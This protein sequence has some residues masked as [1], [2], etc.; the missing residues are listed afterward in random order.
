MEPHRG[1]RPPKRVV[2]STA[3]ASSAAPASASP[4]SHPGFVSHDVVEHDHMTAP[5]APSASVLLPGALREHASHTAP[6][7]PGGIVQPAGF[8]QPARRAGQG[9]HQFGNSR[10]AR[11]R[12]E[13][14]EAAAKKKAEAG[15]EPAP[16]PAP[17]AERSAAGG[18]ADEAA[19]YDLG[20]IDRE[21]AER[22]SKMS[23]E[24]IERAQSDL[25]GMLS[26]ELLQRWKGAAPV[27]ARAAAGGEGAEPAPA[28][29][30]E[31]DPAEDAAAELER[32]KLE[33]TREIVVDVA[34][35]SDDVSAVRYGFEGLPMA[36]SALVSAGAALH[37][38]GEQPDK[39]GYTLAE[40]VHLARSTV[41]GQRVICVE[42]LG[43]V[44]RHARANRSAAT[45]DLMLSA[46]LRLPLLLR[47][48]LDDRS[49]SVV[50]AAIG[51][52]HALLNAPAG[53]GAAL[54]VLAAQYQ[55]W[56]AFPLAPVVALAEGG[57]RLASAVGEDVE[58]DDED[59][60]REDSVGANE[61]L[62]G[63]DLVAGFE[64]MKVVARMRY[65]LEMVDLPRASLVVVLGLL[66]RMTQHSR[67]IATRVAE[68]AGLLPCL[69]SIHDS[70]VSG[71]QSQEG[72]AES[73]STLLMAT[74]GLFE[75]VA[76]ASSATACALSPLVVSLSRLVVPQAAVSTAL[77]IAA[78]R[79]W[80][81]L[82]CHDQRLQGDRLFLRPGHALLEVYPALKDHIQ[83]SAKLD[84]CAAL[85]DCFEVMCSPMQLQ[86]DGV[87]SEALASLTSGSVWWLSELLKADRSDPADPDALT[88]LQLLGSLLHFLS[89][90]TR[91]NRAAV[92]AVSHIEGHI[93]PC[94]D[95]PLF[96]AA[97]TK[98]KAGEL[99]MS[100]P[101]A[102][103]EEDS[104]DRALPC[105]SAA[106]MPVAVPLPWISAALN[107]VLG[108][109][110]WVYHC[111][112]S[113]QAALAKT[114]EI[115]SILELVRVASSL[116][117]AFDAGHG[118]ELSP[119]Q[120][121]MVCRITRVHSLLRFYSLRLG[122]LLGTFS[123]A[124]QLSIAHA[125]SADL[126]TSLGPGDEVI[127]LSALAELFLDPGLLGDL[128]AAHSAEA[129]PVEVADIRKDLLIPLAERTIGLAVNLQSADTKVQ[130]SGGMIFGLDAQ[131]RL[132]VVRSLVCLAFEEP[133]GVND[134][135]RAH[136]LCGATKLMLLLSE[137]TSPL[138]RSLEPEA[139][140]TCSL[141]VME[142]AAVLELDDAV[143]A[144][145]ALM[146]GHVSKLALPA[147]A[148]KQDKLIERLDVALQTFSGVTFGSPVLARA[149]LLL[150]RNNQPV[151]YR[152]ALW[153]HC[154][155]T[156]VHNCLAVAPYEGVGE[157]ALLEPLELDRDMLALYTRVLHSRT[158][159]PRRG[160]LPYRIAVQHTAAAT[161]RP[162]VT[163]EGSGRPPSD[164]ELWPASQ[165]LGE[166][167]SKAA[168][169]V[170]EDVL[171]CAM[172][173]QF[174][175]AGAREEA[176]AVLRAQCET[177]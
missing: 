109:V 88:S 101:E 98:L 74:L 87:G 11:K 61:T 138:V 30:A 134:E 158:P 177:E 129:S 117:C 68:C 57:V 35:G 102:R 121:V 55:G 120:R 7:A 143:A 2:A 54:G 17:A 105:V 18:A 72:D 60:V 21:N 166:L 71:I 13:A 150:A 33:W 28:P 171:A 81:A 145:D 15:A 157:Q 36:P 175:A 24:E 22:L 6:V 65:V 52:L 58:D 168:D 62:C 146:G 49:V 92:S 76:Q 95:S 115:E 132:P 108:A 127:A 123:T 4:M 99:A 154:I 70:A 149:L 12:R 53:D 20:E 130:A 10:F 112:D 48:A 94:V 37:H 23:A 86:A 45:L 50:S 5:T 169:G 119:T 155:D 111:C 64:R 122:R 174:M 73:L 46:E 91:E 125:R 156:G 85:V 44:I 126:L 78:L 128:R 106:T 172:P 135:D 118:M 34:A 31:P 26:P 40:L 59:A 100:A 84:V 25:L 116:G 77:T 133:V 161:L 140:W 9:G 162:F 56:R 89:S 51:A 63:V 153:R 47:Q 136:C 141:R 147:E 107:C 16:Q 97:L 93:Q 75:S 69:I 42:A 148:E 170:L 142:C 14:A 124:E 80:R 19:G 67:P 66:R 8:P 43:A 110:R 144:F 96:Q 137:C 167:K 39:P 41:I 152:S 38:H 32:A 176:G 114:R 82:L 27:A 113:D 3:S 83:L 131:S 164:G 79:C 29:E 104:C 159:A 1:W 163:A 173:A 160:S 165:V 90:H 103:C 151:E 139:V